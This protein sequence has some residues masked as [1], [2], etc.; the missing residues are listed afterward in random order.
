MKAS[1]ASSS[2]HPSSTIGKSGELETGIVHKLQ[3]SHVG[4]KNSWEVNFCT[5]EL[6]LHAQNNSDI[7][8]DTSELCMSK[9]T[10]SA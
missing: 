4:T 9:K 5:D 1:L 10:V 8:Q 7:F 2:N 6:C 3:R